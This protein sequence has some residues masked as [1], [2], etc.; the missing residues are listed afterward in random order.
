MMTY[1]EL[2]IAVELANKDPMFYIGD[3][4]DQLCLDGYFTADAL[5]L[6]IDYLKNRET[7][8]KPS[9]QRTEFDNS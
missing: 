6:M 4:E 2:C 3:W 9:V 7:E 1:K 8:Q 5:Q